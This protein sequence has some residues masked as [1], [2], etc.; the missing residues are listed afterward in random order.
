MHKHGLEKK[1]ASIFLEKAAKAEF[2]CLEVQERFPV[3]DFEKTAKHD[4]PES[5]KKW[6]KI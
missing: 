6:N 3:Q 4:E 2:P 5:I 1:E